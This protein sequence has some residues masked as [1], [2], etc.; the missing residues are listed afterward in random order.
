MTGSLQ[1]SVGKK[2]VI[3]ALH[4]QE[5]DISILLIKALA[6]AL[7]EGFRIGDSLFPKRAY[8]LPRPL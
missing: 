4:P 8:G 6:K 1:V 2:I 5:A 3:T 7:A